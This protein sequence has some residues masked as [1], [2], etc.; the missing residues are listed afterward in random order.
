MINLHLK[1]TDKGNSRDI[2]HSNKLVVNLLPIEIL[3]Q[4]KQSSKLVL[5]NR[6]SIVS[7]VALVFLASA[8]LGLRIS[9]NMAL[10][11]AKQN[12]VMASEKVDS[13]REKEEDILVLKQRLGVIKT[14]FEADTK[15]TGI[16]NL[17]IFL[18]PQDMRIANTTVDKNG[19][20]IISLVAT[21]LA[22]VETLISNLGDKER[23]SDLISSVNLQGLS[24]NN[25]T[26]YRFTL[27]ITPKK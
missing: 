13:L 1:K 7:L 24:L 18:T 26:D 22:S 8:A 16:F 15:I 25:G 2:V 5:I 14:L 21:N 3:L 19:N 12:F 10:E 20:M 6:F 9:Q 23:N 27:N 11:S 17:V 4:R